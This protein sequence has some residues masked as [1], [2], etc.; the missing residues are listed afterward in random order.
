M[1]A[2][3]RGREG[4]REGEAGKRGRGGEGEGGRENQG[5]ASREREP[6]STRQG[7]NTDLTVGGGTNHWPNTWMN[8]GKGG[9]QPS[10]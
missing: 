5:E 10:A 3:L 1:R 6:S 7:R 2:T 9:N 4:H 8:R